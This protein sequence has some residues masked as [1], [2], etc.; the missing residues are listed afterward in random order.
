MKTYQLAALH[1]LCNT[2]SNDNKRGKAETTTT[3]TRAQPMQLIKEPA[4]RKDNTDAQSTHPHTAQPLAHSHAFAH[5]H[6]LTRIRAP[7]GF[8]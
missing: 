7:I 2:N 5:A 4:A 6:T 1:S 8:Y 3:T